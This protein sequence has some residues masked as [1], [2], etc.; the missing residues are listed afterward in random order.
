MAPKYRI[1]KFIEKNRFLSKIK[2]SRIFK[3]SE[4]L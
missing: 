4:M 3:I 1:K 2:I